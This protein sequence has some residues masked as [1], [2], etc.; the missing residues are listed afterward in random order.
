MTGHVRYC[1]LT[2]AI[3][4]DGDRYGMSFC[5]LDLSLCVGRK[6]CRHTRVMRTRVSGQDRAWKKPVQNSV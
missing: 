5:L 3:L 4:R 2:G 6:K 1:V